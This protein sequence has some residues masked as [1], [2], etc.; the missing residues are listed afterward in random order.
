MSPSFR[1]S[2]VVPT[3]NRVEPLR[4]LLESLSAQ[5]LDSGQFELVIADD[6][7][8][9]EVEALAK[10]YAPRFAGLEFVTGPN[11]GPGVAR[12][13]GVAASI[14]MTPLTSTRVSR[15]GT[16]ANAKPIWP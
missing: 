10:A 7:S 2:V 6:G 15:P 12:N 11:A 1:V 8:G 16:G 4:L 9:P 5:Q 13:R 3:F 14:Q